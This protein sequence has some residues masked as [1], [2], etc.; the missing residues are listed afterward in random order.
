MC[1]GSNFVLQFTYTHHGHKFHGTF[2]AF[3]NFFELLFFQSVTIV[4]CTFLSF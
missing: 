1:V 4:L 3:N 2:M